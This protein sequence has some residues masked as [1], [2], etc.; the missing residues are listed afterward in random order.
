MKHLNALVVLICIS[1]QPFLATGNNI[2]ITN[3]SLEGQ[4]FTEQYVFVEFDISW[5][6]S[7]K[8]SAIPANHD[9]AWVFVKYRLAGLEW[10]HMLLRQTGYFA[11]TGSVID[12]VSDSTGAFLYRDATGSGN[13]SWQNVRFR[14]DYGVDGIAD[15]A[16]L[17]V[18]VY[19]I[20]M[21]YM[22][23]AAFYVGDDSA[24]YCFHQG[25]DPDSPFLVSSEGAITINNTASTELYADFN[26]VSGTLQAAYPKGYQAFYCMKY[27]IS[28][29]QYVEFLNTLDR[30]Q[31]NSRTAT[32]ISGTTV[33]N[34]YVMSNEASM[35]ARN[36]IKCDASIGSGIPVNFYCNYTNDQAVNEWDDGQNIACNYLN[37]PDVAAY[38]DWAALRP[39]TSL[40]FEKACRGPNI[41][42]RGEF[43]WG[44]STVYS[45]SYAVTAS[46]TGEEMVTNPGTAIGNCFYS[47]TQ[48]GLGYPDEGP[49]RCGIFAASSPNHTRVETG[50]GYYGVMELSGNI[51]EMVVNIYDV[52]GRSFTGLHGDG[53]LN[54][55]G[56]ADVD[57]WPG[58]NGNSTE[59]VANG[60]YGG[61]TGVTAYAGAG[62]RGGGYDF[63]Q[64]SLMT[65]DRSNVTG[66]FLT[67]RD[68]VWGSRGC[69]TAP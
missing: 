54:A 37:W 64:N 13:V 56:D 21:V 47:S 51:Y 45:S 32:N 57:Y 6:N 34:V 30:D 69:R 3:V 65:S 50:A 18:R 42:V 31:Q 46:G 55:S 7:W 40:E 17:E 66:P 5:E 11:P 26:I 62:I 58:I 28:Q 48:Q 9:A 49:L 8:T 68:D 15:D 1:I 14:W 67:V 43:A 33:T 20:E 63:F 16:L 10:H 29:E 25:N 39:V 19:G 2:Q 61:T 38:L 27:E 36:G 41:P 12:I 35:A 24:T 44:T 23:E 4:V 53:M 60:T 52:A 22:P 59:S